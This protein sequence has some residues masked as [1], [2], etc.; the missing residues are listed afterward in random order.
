MDHR[1]IGEEDIQRGVKRA[2]PLI[3]MTQVSSKSERGQSDVPPGLP[4]FG[5]DA[6]LVTPLPFGLP[7]KPGHSFMKWPCEACILA[8]SRDLQC[9]VWKEGPHTGFQYFC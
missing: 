9:R 2:R 4:V 3:P 5:P 7:A 8:G 1:K 6:D